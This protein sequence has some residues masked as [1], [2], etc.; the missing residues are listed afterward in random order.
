MRSGFQITVSS[1]IMAILA[2]ASDLEGHAR[3]DGQDRRGLQQERRAGHHARPGLRRRH[4]RAHDQGHQ[5]QPAADPRGPA[6]ARARRALRQHRHRAVL[7]HR[8]PGGPEAGGLPRHRERVRRGHRLREVLEPEV[9]VQ[10]PHAPRLGPR[11]HDPGA[12]DARR[13]A[14]GRPGQAAGQGLHREERAAWWRRAS[15]TCSLTS[16]RSSSRASSRWSASTTSTPT[17]TRRWQP[18]ARPPQAAGARVAL[19]KH[20]E[21]GGEGAKELAEVVIDACKAKPKFRF[22]YELST[23][24]RER[25]D[26]I[27]TKVYGAD[28]VSYVAGGHGEGED[29]R[30]RPR[31]VE[32]GHLHGEDAPVPVARPDDQG[33]AE[34]LDAAHPRRAA[35]QGRWLRGARGGRHQAHARA[36]PRTPPSATSTWTWPRAG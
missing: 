20:W 30:G 29:H 27:A 33:P 34:G 35:V 2:V 12:E 9:P 23:P 3:A 32:A 14:P 26:L 25:V 10:R 36:R 6:R 13:R 11:L 21:Q 24:L 17:P 31:A 1:E 19:S 22:L 4:D 28:G 5:P 7:D 16:R 18:C 15:R 8:R